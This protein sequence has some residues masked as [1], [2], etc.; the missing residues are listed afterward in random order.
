MMYIKGEHS[1]GRG[2][3]TTPFLRPLF[4]I[5][6]CVILAQ[7][8]VAAMAEMRTINGTVAYRERMALPPGASVEIKLVDGSRADA[9][10]GTIAETT[11]VPEGQV[12]VAYRLTY[13]ASDILPGRSYALQARITVGGRLM[14][15]T[16]TRHPIFSDGADRTDIIVERV[17]GADP[18]ASPVGKWLAEDIRGGGVID[19]LQTV[20]NIAEDG[21]VTGTGGC[22]RMSGKAV[23]AND[24]IKFSPIAATACTPAAMDQEAKFFAALQGVRAW[25][26][27]PIRRKLV[28]LD[29]D[30]NR[31][32]VFTRL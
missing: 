27:N 9:P 30:G 25:H 10:S 24:S 32:I 4:A 18:T 28:L 17:K 31:L 23:I 5:L 29:G 16:T 26:V 8:T 15:I 2:S 3:M 12:P 11:I 13:E 6:I 14:F 1:T 22:N 21:T 19:R 20:L 7:Q